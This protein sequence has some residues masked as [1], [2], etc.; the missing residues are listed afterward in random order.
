MPS[1]C[2]LLYIVVALNIFLTFGGNKLLLFI[3]TIIILNY[4]VFE[5]P[6]KSTQHAQKFSYLYRS[7]INPAF[8][9]FPTISANIFKMLFYKGL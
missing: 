4:F 8:S 9:R 5:I 1:I 6:V 7:Y 3:F 2:F